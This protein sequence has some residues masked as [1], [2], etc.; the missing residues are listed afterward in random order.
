MISVVRIEHSIWYG[1]LMRGYK[2]TSL[3]SCI[4][5]RQGDGTQVWKYFVTATRTAI[6]IKR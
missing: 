2:T 5:S 3:R 1:L 4:D 6:K